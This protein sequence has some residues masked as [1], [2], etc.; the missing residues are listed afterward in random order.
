MTSVVGTS[1][2]A[3]PTATL[4]QEPPTA[5]WRGLAVR[6]APR[7][8]ERLADDDEREAASPQ[9]SK[10]TAAY[11]L[12]FWSLCSE[13]IERIVPLRERIT[14]E[15]VR[16]AA[17][18][19]AH[20]LHQLAVGDAGGDEEAVVAGD[21]VVG[22][23]HVVGVEVV[24]GVEG[25]LPLLVVLGPEPALD[26]AVEALHRAGGDDAL[27]GAA[28]AE[29]QVDAGAGAGGHDRAGDVAVGDELDPG[30]G[31]ADLVDQLLR[32]AAGRAAR[33]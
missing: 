13:V 29:Q 3:S 6:R 30:A 10:S 26:H 24:A 15:W 20:A 14:S 11:A 9:C 31:R 17:G 5:S 4:R 22:G 1:S 28:D 33:R 18:A 8:D 7:V 25:P 21:Q 12:S 32:G 2:R 23:E 19:V 27:G 16:G